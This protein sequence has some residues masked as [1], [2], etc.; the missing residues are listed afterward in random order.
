M[1]RE[2]RGLSQSVLM[3]DRLRLYRE[4]SRPDDWCLLG[5]L[6]VPLLLTFTGQFPVTL[7][8]W[9]LGSLAGFAS[10]RRFAK[11]GLNLLLALGVLVTVATAL[12]QHDMLSSS[13]TA[14]ITQLLWF[15]LAVPAGMHFGSVS[16][17]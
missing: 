3:Q 14:P 6:L 9:F 12:I 11:P 5:L 4:Q 10:Y 8:F 7:P 13:W 2:A 1:S 15:S 17:S 16:H